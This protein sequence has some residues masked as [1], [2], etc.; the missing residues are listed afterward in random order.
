MATCMLHRLC[1]TLTSHSRRFVLLDVE[2]IPAILC[3]GVEGLDR[4][5]SGV[6]RRRY[7]ALVGRCIKS[8]A[9]VMDTAQMLC[10][11][12]CVKVGTTQ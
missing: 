12:E 10:I 4:C 3:G 9:R 1:D 6:M 8:Q 7:G 5:R 2:H 11:C